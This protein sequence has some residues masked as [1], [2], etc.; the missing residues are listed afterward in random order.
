MSR[1]LRTALKQAEFD[2]D[3]RSTYAVKLAKIC[4]LR[5]LIN[6][7]KDK[8]FGYIKRSI[9]NYIYND[10]NWE[11]DLLD[12]LTDPIQDFS[13]D[14]AFKKLPQ[15]RA[16]IEK[17]VYDITLHEM[18]PGTKEPVEPEV[19]Q[20]Y[21]IC[22]FVSKDKLYKKLSDVVE[23]ITSKLNGIHQHSLDK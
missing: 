2:F 5:S 7:V 11:Y 16:L 14:S 19:K 4:D 18:I 10:G 22:L 21:Y 3:S 12:V 15:E 17:A 23:A 6:K 13:I 1:W 8:N 9:E 20:Q